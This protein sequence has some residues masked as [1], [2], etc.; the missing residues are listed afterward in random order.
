[1]TLGATTDESRLLQELQGLHWMFFNSGKSLELPI[2]YDRLLCGQSCLAKHTSCLSDSY[3]TKW[4]DLDCNGGY[5][6]YVLNNEVLR[7]SQ[8][9]NA[10]DAVNY[11]NK[12][13]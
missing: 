5:F 6:V 4:L 1:M 11:Y 9:D 10:A 2:V 7:E 8:F 3:S 13:C 12:L